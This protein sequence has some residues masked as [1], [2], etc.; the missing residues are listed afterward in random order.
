M[1]KL[2]QGARAP[3]GRMG[4]GRLIAMMLAAAFLAPAAL[5]IVPTTTAAIL[6]PGPMPGYGDMD[7][8]GVPHYFGPYPNYANSPVPKGAITAVTVEDF[9]ENYT[10]PVVTIRDAWGTGAGATAI[11]TVV[12]GV[13]TNITVTSGG[14][15]YSAPEVIITDPTGTNASA[16]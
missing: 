10:A 11:A 8:N 12:D 5:V 6:P 4:A 1:T 9:G 15:G 2:F 3:R 16:T 13:V 14:H 7:P